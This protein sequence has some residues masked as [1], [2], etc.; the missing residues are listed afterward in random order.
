MTKRNWAG[1]KVLIIGA[2]RQGLALARFLAARGAAVTLNDQHT[3][4]QLQAEMQ[5]MAGLPVTW[6]LGGHPLELLDQAELVCVSGGVPL[7]LPIVTEAQRR[8]LPLTN[9]SQIFIEAVP[10]PVIGIT[11]SAG[12]TTTTTLVGRAAE[13]AAKTGGMKA[14]VGGNIGLPLVEYVEE[15]Q[16][17]D[18]VLVEL[19]SFQLELMNVSPQVAAVLNIT[20]NHLDRHG[21]LE[22]YTAA[23]ARTLAFQLAADTAVLNREDPA[24]WAL[25]DKVRG[26]LVTFGTRR[27]E[28]GL[29]GTF[30]E[31][32]SLYYTDGKQEMELLE[33][34]Q[35]R[36]R[37]AH[38]LLNVLAAG[39]IICAAGMPAD[40]LRS[41]VENFNGVAHRLEFVRTWQGA[42]W[43]NDSKA[44]SPAETIAAIQAFDEPLVLLLGGRD[45]DLPW[46]KLAELAHQR[47]DHIVVFGEAAEKIFQALG[48]VQPGRRLK[49]IRRETGLKAAVDAA[50]SVV[51]PGHIVLLSPGGTSF[52]EFKDFE[53]RGERYREWVRA[54]S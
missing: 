49:S 37:G 45:K 14:W 25:R 9:D 15:I 42:D 31:N 23:K 30:T 51:Q 24:A 54:L 39:A 12:K 46:D 38:N 27:P 16:P 8:G 32:G 48:P 20:P 41:A 18:L 17:E 40:S 1:V 47:I 2:A 21:T 19:S 43:Y 4:D 35:I 7:T 33:E 13:A 5:S 28:A 6:V 29:P 10:A 52:D 53:Q 36:L 3:P 34:P 22:A 26:R 44:T 50:A 11:G